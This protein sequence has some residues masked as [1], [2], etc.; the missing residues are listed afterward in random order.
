MDVRRRAQLQAGLLVK[1]LTGKLRGSSVV[2][3]LEREIVAG[4]VRRSTWK[5]AFNVDVT[6]T[7]APFSSLMDPA[8]LTRP[9]ED[10]AVEMD[11]VFL[12][13]DVRRGCESAHTYIG[14]AGSLAG[15]VQIT[16]SM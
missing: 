4:A 6:W 2:A 3:E 15:Y 1:S 14:A 8:G 5:I 11:P 16:D 12:T 9:D 7:L 10:D 13:G